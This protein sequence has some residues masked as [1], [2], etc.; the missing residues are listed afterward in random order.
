MSK[1]INVSDK[2]YKEL[3]NMKGNRSF[4]EVILESLSKGKK[5]NKEAVLRFFG[6]D[7]IDKK[8]LKELSK[9]WK[10]WSEKYA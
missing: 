4:S 10:K 7:L 6:K 1:L 2:V 9:G 3:S 8:K 5:S